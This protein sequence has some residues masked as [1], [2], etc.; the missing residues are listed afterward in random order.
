MSNIVLTWNT[1]AAEILNVHTNPGHDTRRLAII[2][3]AIHDA[4]NSVNE[5][6]KRYLLKTKPDPGTSHVA[7]VSSAA[8]LT[9]FWAISDRNNYNDQMKKENLQT[10]PFSSGIQYQNILDL[11][12]LSLGGI[13]DGVAKSNGVLLGISAAAAILADRAY[14]NNSQV[15]L[16]SA[17]PDGI[18]AG[19]FRADYY[20][21]PPRPKNKFVAN[22]GIVKP[23]VFTDG[24]QFQQN[25]MY[26]AGE[27]DRD[28]NEVKTKGKLGYTLLPAEKKVMDVWSNNRQHIVWNNIASEILTANNQ[29]EWKAAKVFALM[30]TAMADGTISMFNDT[31]NKFYKWRPVTAFN[32]PP[33]I[34][35]WE[36]A[37]QPVPRVPEYP[38]SWGILAGAA[39]QILENL[40]TNTVS[41][42][43]KD[44]TS[45]IT[46]NYTTISRALDD[47][48]N[49]TI[50]CGWNFRKSTVD[51]IK[52][53]R[54]I[55]NYVFNNHFK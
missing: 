14:D 12:N 26:A 20:S 36:P 29:D 35:P 30:H 54:L 51:S 10:A 53:G 18:N 39:G 13:P 5:I 15:E 22:Y 33:V 47:V 1:K 45:A 27:Q 48:T 31:Y 19:D 42:N 41:F 3:I 44:A 16:L 8:Y 34:P 9:L 2:H 40:F 55:G 46:L 52:Q 11:Y 28:Y 24:V 23:F 6:N 7:A 37:K 25:P 49:A 4:L 50:Y 43:V 21:D 38:S 17:K 32:I